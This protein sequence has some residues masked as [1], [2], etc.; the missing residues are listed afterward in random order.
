[1]QVIQKLETEKD[2]LQFK[3]DEGTKS[4]EIKIKELK[5]QLKDFS[6]KNSEDEKNLTEKLGEI[7]KLNE[8]KTEYHNKT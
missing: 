2:N 1:M 7:D 8:L 6:N 5:L 3:R 4:L